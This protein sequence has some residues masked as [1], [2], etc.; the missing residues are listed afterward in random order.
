MFDRSV[1]VHEL[2]HYIQ[3]FNGM[4][5][6]EKQAITAQCRWLHSL[7]EDPRKHISFNTILNLTGDETF[8]QLDWLEAA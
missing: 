2:V 1:L 4:P 6:C 7:G 5:S 8:A 3:Q